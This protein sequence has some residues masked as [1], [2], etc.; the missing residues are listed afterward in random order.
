MQRPVTSAHTDNESFAFNPLLPQQHSNPA[1]VH[2]VGNK[3]LSETLIV[4][5]A[6]DEDE[7]CVRPS[8]LRTPRCAHSPVRVDTI[9]LD[10]V[11][12]WDV[13][14]RAAAD[15]PSLSSLL[16]RACAGA[17]ATSDPDACEADSV[18]P[19][20]WSAVHVDVDCAQTPRAH[21]R[22]RVSTELEWRDAGA[23]NSRDCRSDAAS[24]GVDC[25]LTQP[26]LLPVA[27]NIDECVGAREGLLVPATA[28]MAQ[29]QPQA[30][31]NVS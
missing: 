30:G 27:V 5:N 3:Q 12:S 25:T 22:V 29:M 1:F 26:Y 14:D 21:L 8:S 31:K 19:H 13:K 10:T 9:H 24:N 15:S 6:K 2:P 16:E 28:P 20:D 18:G 23:R 11:F 4:D 7:P 17:S